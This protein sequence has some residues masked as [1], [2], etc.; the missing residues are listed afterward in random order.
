MFV[1]VN[2]RVKVSRPRYQ[3]SSLPIF[4]RT[5]PLLW[6][7]HHNCVYKYFSFCVVFEIMKLECVS[8]TYLIDSV[9]ICVLLCSYSARCNNAYLFKLDLLDRNSWGIRFRCR[10]S[11]R[12]LVFNGTTVSA[13]QL[14]LLIGNSPLDG[15]EAE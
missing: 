8:L 12:D 4:M 7:C 13:L 15:E 11:R 2:W 10:R 6:L 3:N 1:V 9:Q 5:S 14:H